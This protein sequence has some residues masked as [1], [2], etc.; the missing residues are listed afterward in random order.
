MV[1]LTE[2]TAR[3]VLHVCY[4]CDDADA[5]SADLVDGLG[6]IDTMRTPLEPS[7]GSVLGLTGEIVSRAHFLFDHRGPRVSPA[8]EVQEWVRPSTV[9]SPPSDPRQAGTQ[10]L[11][12]AVADVAATMARLDRLGWQ[13]VA[14]GSATA[15]VDRTGVRWELVADAQI[16]GPSRL[17]HLAVT[18]SD[19]VASVDFY[20]ALGWSVLERRPDGP[21]HRARL[22]LADEPFELH[23]TQWLDP[24]T[25]G[26][27]PA[28]ANHAGLFRVALGV[29][30]TRLAHAELV[31]RGLAFDRPPRAI[32]LH[33]TNV[34][35]M[36]I[37]FLHDPDGVAIELV[38]R[39]R[40]AFR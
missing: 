3:R 27:H 16:A 23:L 4:C 7:D 10:A 25:H 14:A 15:L 13:Q 32:E 8:I 26:R 17:A 1:D 18:V 36:W 12:V 31:G 24:P 9:G 33:G 40:S 5:V 39:P 11:G 34:P 29:D 6:L 2:P 30:D 22:R 37:A 28:A 38:G 21:A 20:G 35:P 19:L